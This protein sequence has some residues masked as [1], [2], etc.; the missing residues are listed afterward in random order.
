[1]K[2]RRSRWTAEPDTPDTGDIV[3][4][5]GKLKQFHLLFFLVALPRGGQLAVPAAAMGSLPLVVVVGFVVVFL[6]P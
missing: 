1:L 5:S 3:Q 4:G 2:P 6:L